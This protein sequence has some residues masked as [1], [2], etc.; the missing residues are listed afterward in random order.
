MTYLYVGPYATFD[1]RHLELQTSRRGPVQIQKRCT[2][3]NLSNHYASR[4]KFWM[5]QQSMLPDISRSPLL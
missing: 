2:K 3:T 1:D 4:E 5:T